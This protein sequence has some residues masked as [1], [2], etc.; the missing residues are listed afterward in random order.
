MNIEELQESAR[1]RD[2]ADGDRRGRAALRE[3]ANAALASER[4]ARKF[5]QSLELILA[6]R[7]WPEAATYS[8]HGG[9]L[10]SIY[11]DR[12]GDWRDSRSGA[13]LRVR[14]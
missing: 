10:V 11:V 12:Q 3:A 8:P 7:T 2:A 14:S 4:E 13:L 1:A 6:T 9:S 5:T